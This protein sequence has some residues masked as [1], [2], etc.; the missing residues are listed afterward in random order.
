MEPDC[1]DKKM[2]KG[3]HLKVY[4]DKDRET[5]GKIMIT[6]IRRDFQKSKNDPIHVYWNL[7][8]NRTRRNWV[9]RFS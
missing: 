9:K 7:P 2:E 6:Q 8:D 4:K 1:K 3:R 5:R